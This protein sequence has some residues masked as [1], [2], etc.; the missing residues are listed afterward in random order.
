MKLK[1]GI[2]S[3]ECC[4]CAVCV[5]ICPKHALT[6]KPDTE[7]FEY[8]NLD[9]NACVNCGACT[10]VCPSVEKNTNGLFSKIVS[11]NAF[12]HSDTEVFLQSSSG[13]AFTAIAQTFYNGNCAIFGAESISRSE[14]KHSFVEN[15]SDLGKFRKSKYLQS[16]TLGIFSQVQSKL[17]AGKNVLFTGTA[18]Q[19]A[20]L[21]LF[22]KKGYPTLLTVDVA[23]H[24]VNNS[25][26]TESYLL[27][28]EKLY[29]KKITNY[30]FRTKGR[31]FGIDRCVIAEFCFSDG[32]KKQID[33][34]I[35]YRG[36]VEGLFLRKSCYSCK[37]S[38]KNRVADFTIADFWGI[39]RLSDKFNASHGCSLI[40]ANTKKATNMLPKF[41][42][43]GI[44]ENFDIEE[45]CH[46][47]I[48]LKGSRKPSSAPREEFINLALKSGM[49]VAL[50]KFTH[51]P[52]LLERIISRI[53]N[54]LP[55]PFKDVLKKIRKES[56]N[57]E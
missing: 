17:K 56:H 52:T 57:K 36:F 34:D 41:S 50:K 11:A 25:K 10:T 14:V 40:C 55:T 6:M 13:G 54:S 7:G 22:L 31:K 43:L 32:S 49:L 20:A 35:L 42:E 21:R 1:T 29:G 46:Y 2:E 5:E 37:F 4:G 23:C 8:P 19:V 44:L 51:M 47:I 39:E 26:L 28:C 9:T 24:G 30:S 12:V 38:G 16:N 15:I 3:D 45:A 33:H 53:I 48:P 27:D 18:C